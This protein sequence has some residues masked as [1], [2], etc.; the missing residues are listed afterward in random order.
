MKIAL[1][2]TVVFSLLMTI[3]LLQAKADG[4]HP[5]MKAWG[6]MIPVLFILIWSKVEQFKAIRKSK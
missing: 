1:I 2:I 6:C 5:N 3:L 4:L